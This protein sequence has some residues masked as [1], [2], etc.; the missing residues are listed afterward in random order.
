MKQART[1]KPIITSVVALAILLFSFA[2]VFS[3]AVVTAQAATPTLPETEYVSP[4]S[5][6]TPEP[7]DG[8]PVTPK[9]INSANYR[10]YGLTD[11][12]WKQYNGYY[13]IRNAKE[14]YGFAALTRAVLRPNQNAVLLADIVINTTVSTETGGTYLWES[15]VGDPTHGNDG[16]YA[17]TFDGNGYSI[18]GIYT[19]SGSLGV[20]FGFFGAINNAGVVKN[21]VLKNSVFLSEGVVAV[22]AQNHC[23]M[24]S[25]CRVESSVILKNEIRGEVSGVASIDRLNEG[26]NSYVGGIEN[27]YSAATLQVCEAPYVGVFA[28]MIDS[29]KNFK[30]NYGIESN[31]FKMVGNT[32]PPTGAVTVLTSQ[33]DAHVCIP[34]T[35]NQVNGTCERSGLS[36]YTYC[37]VCE[38]VLSG[39]KTVL[40]GHVSDEFFYTINTNDE[41][42]H[43][44]RYMCCTEIA[45]TVAHTFDNDTCTTCGYEMF[46]R[47]GGVA[48]PKAK[49]ITLSSNLVVPAGDTLS[50]PAGYTMTVP[51]G[52]TLTVKGNL[53]NNGTLN[54]NGGVLVEGAYSGSGKVNCASTAI[55]HPN[56]NADGFCAFCQDETHPEAAPLVGG[57]YQIG[58]VGQLMWFSNFVGQG[59]GSANAKLTAD[60]TFNAGDLSGLNGETSGKRLWVP[61]GMIMDHE[62]GIDT[63]VTYTGIFDGD[64]H[65]ISGLYHFDYWSYAGNAGLISKLGA[66]GIV[67][68]VTVKNSYFATSSYVGAIVG[69]NLGGLI[70]NCHNQNTTIAS[71]ARAGG[72]VGD[73]TSGTVR[74]CTNSGNVKFFAVNSGLA[75]NR[76][77]FGGIAGSTGGLVEYCTNN[78]TVSGEISTAGGISGQVYQGTLRNN[79]NNGNVNITSTNAGGIT[80]YQY[81]GTLSYNINY[82]TVQGKNLVGGVIGNALGNGGRYTHNYTVGGNAVG[83]GTKDGCTAITESELANGRLAFELGMGQ[84]LGVDARPSLDG[85]AV[86]AYY[87][88]SGALNYTNDANY[89]CYHKGGT[90]TCDARAICDGCRNPYGEIPEGAH[91]FEITGREDKPNCTICGGRCGVVAPHSTNYIDYCA[92][93]G[94]WIAPVLA[95]DGFYEIQTFGNLMWFAETVNAGN[96]DL[97]A[98][99]TKNI[100]Y[101]ASYRTTEWVPIAGSSI[102]DTTVGYRGIFDGQGYC[103]AAF[104]QN[105]IPAYDGA[106]LGLFGTLADGAVVK[107]L[108]IS[109]RVEITF[110][111][112]GTNYT[113]GGE[114]TVY[115]GLVAGRVLEGATVS[116]CRVANGSVS[117]SKGVLGAIVG[118]NYGT[119][120]NCV[121]YNMTL[122][123]P[124]GHVGGIVGDYNGGELI[125]CYTTY[126][127]LGSTASGYVGT[128]I[129]SEAGVSDKR[130]ASGEIAYKM[131][132]YINDIDF[133]Y[134]AIGSGGPIGKSEYNLVGKIVYACDFGATVLYSNKSG[135]F[136]LSESFVI[137]NGATF[138]VPTGT[139][140]EI[141]QD[142]TLTNNG[143]L[144]KNGDLKG[145]GTL[146]GN[147]RFIITEIN[148]SVI[149]TVSDLVYDGNNHMDDIITALNNAFTTYGKLFTPEGYTFYKSSDEVKNV[150]SYEIGYV[151]G[152]ERFTVQFS[153]LV[154]AIQDG[155]I[156]L[157]ATEFLYN[158]TAFEPEVILNGYSTM[159]GRDYSVSFTNNTSAGTASV[160]IVFRGNFSGEFTREFTIKPAVI[161]ESATVSIPESMTFTGLALEPVELLVGDVILTY[162]VDYTVTYTDNVYPGMATVV[163]VGMGSVS[164]E[165]T[166]TFE[167]AKPVFNITVHD[168]ILP[169]NENVNVKEFDQTA[170]SG[171]GLIDGHTVVL[172]EVIVA[173]DHGEVITVLAILD[174]NGV[175]VKEYYDLTVITG[176]YHMFSQYYR[177]DSDGYHW[178]ECVYN[179]DEICDYEQH[180]GEPA[181]CVDHS[182]CTLCGTYYQF[183]TG[184]HTWV[185]SV[186]TVCGTEN[187]YEVWIDTDGNGQFNGDEVGY[188]NLVTLLAYGESGTYKLLKDVTSPVYG[189]G[190]TGQR[191]VIDLYGRTFTITAH[192]VLQAGDTII[193]F[194]D[195]SPN[196]TGKII[197]T[198]D[199]RIFE[200]AKIILDGVSLEGNVS[201]SNGV[202][203]LKN[204]ATIDSYKSSGG[205]ILLYEGYDLTQLT[206]NPSS[207]TNGYDTSIYVGDTQLVHN[208]DTGAL[209]CSENHVFADADCTK[210][211]HCTVCGKEEGDP[212]GHDTNGPATCEEDEYCS[213]CESV[214]QEAIGHSEAL[215]E[216]KDPTCTEVGYTQ[217]SYCANNCGTVF[218]QQTEI[219]A[220][221][222][223]AGEATVEN[224]VAVT[225]TTDGSY[226]TVVSCT[227]CGEELSRVTETVAAQGHNE[228]RSVID[229]SLPSCTYGGWVQYLYTCQIC[230]D[231]RRELDYLD[232]IGHTEGEPYVASQRESTCTI[233]G[234]IRTNVNCSVCGENIS[235]NEEILPL[236]EHVP[237]V[238]AVS[239][240][241]S[242]YCV[243]CA[244]PLEDAAEHSYVETV[245]EAS[246]IQAGGIYYACS[247]CGT[248]YFDQTEDIK[249]HTP[250]LE[251]ATCTENKECT[252]CEYV[253]ESA[254]G[255]TNVWSTCTTPWYC[256][257][258]GEEFAPADGHIY[259]PAE[260]PTCT[261]AQY[262]VVCGE[263]S[264]SALG[265]DPNREAPTCEDPV[266]CTRCPAVLEVAT[267]HTNEEVMGTPATCTESGLT[268]GVVCTVCGVVTTP[269]MTIPANGHTE[270]VLEGIPE[271]CEANGLTEGKICLVCGVV[272]QEQEVILTSG[273][274]YEADVTVADCTSG[275]FILFTCSICGDSYVGDE[276]E[277]LGHS[278]EAVVTAPDCTSGG[279]TTYTCSI[280]G[281]SYVD[282]VT[283]ALEHSYDAVVTAPDC[284]NGGATTYICSICGDSY[285]GDITA[286]LGHSNE[287]FVTI[288]DCTNGGFTTYTCTVCGESYVVDVTEAL[289]HSYKVVVTAPDCSNGGFTTYT[290]T[291]CGVSYTGDATAALGHRYDD[292][293]D[294][295]CSRCGYIR[296]V[297]CSHSELE[298]VPGAV[299]TCT[300]GG[301]TEGKKCSVCDA[302]ILE[303]EA[304]PV[305]GHTEV[306]VPSKEATCTEAGLT[307]GK[308][309]SV[310]D[311]IILAQSPIQALGHT[312]DDANDETCNR[313]DY[314]RDVA[315]THTETET[316]P[317]TPATCTESGLTDGKKCSVC[318]E[319]L[320]AQ[321]TIPAL[322]HTEETVKG[323]AATCTES[324]L[325]DGKKCSVCD[326]ILLE[327]QPIAALGHNVVKV[328]GKAATCT[329]D[330]YRAHYK[331]TVCEALYADEACTDE[332]FDLETWQAFEGCIEA[333]HTLGDI[334]PQKPA[335]CTNTGLEAHYKC[336]VCEALVDEYGLTVTEEDLKLPI[337]DSA[338]DLG[339]WQEEIPATTES[340]GTK[341][342]YHCSI[343]EKNFD[344]DG[345]EISDLS[346]PKLEAPDT[347][348]P[349]EP[350]PD[351]Q[352]EQPTEEPKEGLSGSAVAG[353]VVASTVVAGAGGFS[354]FWFVVQKKSAAELVT[355][356]KAVA[357]KAGALC[358]QAGGKI[359]DVTLNLIEKI[360]KLFAK[361]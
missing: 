167:I 75:F 80:G 170:Y 288:P 306:T 17:G 26:G 287:V 18:S 317:G 279:F 16:G 150:G 321:E 67:K 348:E 336:S 123:G 118:V 191:M 90:A 24:V 93:C 112:S 146:N 22:F 106:V 45:E 218:V 59:N 158:G 256:S 87:N 173:G 66:G 108:S 315:C 207:S 301:L 42:K 31:G 155:D 38:K 290:C 276:T 163:I 48:T 97:N 248:S 169:Y 192:L 196:K 98:R 293:N 109:N 284:T 239:C 11:E 145:S 178:R 354:I 121:S 237:N 153:I 322:G 326:E 205:S 335:D 329:T 215:L 41:F 92:V 333:A 340:A 13:A 172:G 208:P 166:Y 275:G 356:T 327:Q 61:I 117:I 330:G 103:I 274:S 352:P 353:I 260:G 294:E 149:P 278:Y 358:K 198:L 144:V 212:L 110:N 266:E 262:C 265:H 34:I 204:G 1:I 99:L 355:A 269:Q 183:A 242:K 254:F 3:G 122:S 127:S 236:A 76:E 343:C 193:T 175:D 350:T 291:A 51:N 277:A 311:V 227:V 296:D 270:A 105:L 209:E 307:D 310:C 156:S 138:T 249:E 162:G 243:I 319:I 15:I 210:P 177:Y 27:T 337:D 96:C 4:K 189:I 213:R 184:I 119:V 281:D 86:Y 83:S 23:G 154:L 351:A 84:K 230:G 289:G 65:T 267:G 309:C 229:Q 160:T 32:T 325:T 185:D 148:A 235:S 240:I 360:K 19:K 161:G 238:D 331:C 253:Y 157:N 104:P 312:Y 28:G 219:P 245:Q 259:H 6:S 195:T 134:Q 272:I 120:E 252:V 280:C 91:K 57:Y 304:V 71:A 74:Y 283:A 271:S 12:N 174:A 33:N 346:I 35:H 255:H 70:E 258:C 79:I 297:A 52:I 10:S 323:S 223:T 30:N 43:D 347:P 305:L 332:I 50:I 49:N 194:I 359:K 214:I 88:N 77:S 147:G 217:G 72:I 78:G 203:E 114:Y 313:C 282:D 101:G 54:N 257:T 295:S 318:E 228:S 226:D 181:T 152:D 250:N 137:T 36:A 251:H 246:C 60:I 299:A 220:L 55:Y 131:N 216:A 303:Q 85:P 222:H 345:Y 7:Y 113:Y 188:S 182:M 125:N 261:E 187:P 102:N 107:N 151:K 53:V 124:A 64:G 68:N 232:P 234:F 324:G 82:G 63:F 129:D 14:L 334:I 285:V 273:H 47:E 190:T 115:F 298:T 39:E 44:K 128:A 159:L 349:E 206:I 58:N 221:G 286:A 186:C 176:E 2:G 202:L 143:T 168:Q 100:T 8:V 201:I 136:T 81:H 200:D 224:E 139:T 197:G 116:G 300:A 165:G 5:P 135:Q 89:T 361:K 126:A 25:A 328:D 142:V 292:E 244:Q 268:S 40:Y 140:L 199:I 141:A 225:C 302:V 341:A 9:Q 164:G 233:E 320:V 73:N 46:T 308:K 56:F 344:D 21:L 342:H 263:V 357:T 231:T 94:D 29:S 316:I 111:G 69:Q 241:E 179:C 247:V 20:N 211:M 338:H 62:T 264:A 37:A 132:T 339:K 314:V 133:W 130:M 180:I 171:E 95:E